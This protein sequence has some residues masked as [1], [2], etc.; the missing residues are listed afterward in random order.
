MITAISQVQRA[1]MPLRSHASAC[2][3]SPRSTCR[4]RSGWSRCARSAMPSRMPRRSRGAGAGTLVYVGRFDLAEF[5]VVLEPEEPLRTARRALYAGMVALDRRAARARAAGEADRLRLARR[6][7]RRWRPCRRRRGSPGRDGAGG[8]TAGL[9]GVRRHDPH[10]GDGRGRAGAAS[11]V[12]GARGGRLR[13]CRLR[14]AGRELRAPSHGAR[15]TPGRST[16][17]TRSRR[18]I[19]RGLRPKAACAATSTTTAICWCGASGKGADTER[20]SLVAA[21][22]SRRGSIRRP[23]ARADEAA[24]HHPAR[25]LRHLR[26]RARAEP[27]EWAVSGAFMFCRRRSVDAGRQGACGIPRGLPRRRVARLVDAG[28]DRR[29]ERRRSRAPRS[30]TLAKQLRRA[31]RRARASR[32]RCGGGRG[33]RVRGFALQSSRSIR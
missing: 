9:A 20:R 23:G 16:D 19:L 32:M 28:A 24:A 13:R 8:R 2:R 11:A 27:G 5:A 3:L 7:P 33:G 26:V 12:G 25:S 6:D 21:L 30:S 4:R 15:S 17:S 1:E 18:A 31:F 14:P 10:R 22:A 29:G